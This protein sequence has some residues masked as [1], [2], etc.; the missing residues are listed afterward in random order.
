MASLLFFPTFKLLRFKK[1]LPQVLSPY[2]RLP[3]FL[4]SFYLFGDGLSLYYQ[5]I[6]EL[7]GSRD[8]PASAFQAAGTTGTRQQAQQPRRLLWTQPHSLLP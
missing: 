3:C 4:S 7:L 1:K 8:S 5:P 6:I 2:I